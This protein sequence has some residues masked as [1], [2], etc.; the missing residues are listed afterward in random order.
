MK[1]PF[2]LEWMG[3]AAEHHFRKARPHTDD[4]P[5]GT[6]DASRYDPAAVERA[7]GSWTEV[8]INEYRAVASFSEVLRALVDAKAP[9]DLLGMT[10]DFLADECAHVEL[11]SRMAMELGG[12]APGRFRSLHRAAPPGSHGVAARER[13]CAPRELHLR[14]VQRRHGDRELRGDLAPSAARRLRVHSSRRSAPPPPRGALLRVG[15]LADRRSRAS[16]PRAGLARVAARARPL[17][18][19]ALGHEQGGARVVGGRS[20]RPRLARPGAVRARRE[21]GRGA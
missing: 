1:V 10:S 21:G 18:E 9:L 20:R 17:L 5:W 8:A 7:R 3:G 13:A 15:P 4:L 2:E 16:P 6:V 14:G 11:A 19:V 12:A